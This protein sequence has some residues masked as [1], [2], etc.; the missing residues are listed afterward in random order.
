MPTFMLCLCSVLH[1]TNYVNCNEM[2]IS[3]PAFGNNEFHF[4]RHTVY[5]LLALPACILYSCESCSG[6]N[7]KQLTA[8]Q[9]NRGFSELQR[10]GHLI[11]SVC[12]RLAKLDTEHTHTHDIVMCRCTFHLLWLNQEDVRCVRAHVHVCVCVCV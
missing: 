2:V 9:H 1:P 8:E 7:S 10:H 12:F 6:H 5:Y 4:C 3:T 11:P